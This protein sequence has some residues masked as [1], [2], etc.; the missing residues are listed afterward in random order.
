M[1]IRRQRGMRPFDATIAAACLAIT[2]A[3]R[4]D[5]PDGATAREVRFFSEGVACYAKVF[6]PKGFTADGKAP[7]VVLAPAPGDTA[8][9]TEKYA[10]QFAGRGLIAMVIDYRGWG[11]S[12]AFLYVAE[13][14]RWAVH[15]DDCYGWRKLD[16]LSAVHF[17]HAALSRV[18]FRAQYF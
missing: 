5:V 16:S 8:A 10:A 4:A 17:S 13:P 15:G 6:T 11:R 18:Q 3:A 2:V 12:G 9:S 7:A 14:V 1:S